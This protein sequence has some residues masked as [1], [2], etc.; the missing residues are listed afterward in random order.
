M[1]KK[2]FHKGS[3]GWGRDSYEIPAY[4]VA[5]CSC[6]GED[7]PA[8]EVTAKAEM[9]ALQAALREAGIDSC[10]KAT[11]SG[12]CCMVKVWVCVTASN[13][14]RAKALA[15]QWLADHRDDTRLIHDAD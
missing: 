13:Y 1:M 8:P 6:T 12:N 4:A 15:D 7:G 10:Y 3:D 5:G 11:P 9:D 2:R 14:D